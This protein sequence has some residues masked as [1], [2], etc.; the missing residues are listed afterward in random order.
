VIFSYNEE[1]DPSDGK[2]CFVSIC[3]PKRVNQKVRL[4]GMDGMEI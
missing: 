4:E 1:F 3:R 2:S